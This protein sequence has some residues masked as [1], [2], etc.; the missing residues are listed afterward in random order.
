MSFDDALTIAKAIDA[1]AALAAA[2]ALIV[3]AA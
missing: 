1:L 3:A 2:M